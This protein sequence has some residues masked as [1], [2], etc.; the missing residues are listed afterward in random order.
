[1]GIAILLAVVSLALL[2]GAAVP[3]EDRESN[4]L[5]LEES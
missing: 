5:A 2:P 3:V 1:M 4:K